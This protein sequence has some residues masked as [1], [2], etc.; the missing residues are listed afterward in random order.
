MQS[1]YYYSRR[2]RFGLSCHTVL[3]R[4][5][6]LSSRPPQEPTLTSRDGPYHVTV[7][8]LMSMMHRLDTRR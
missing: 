8:M 2:L 5:K 6:R 4:V 7:Y 1:M 3:C